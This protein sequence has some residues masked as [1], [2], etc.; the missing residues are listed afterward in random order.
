MLLIV[1]TE[2]QH[3]MYMFRIGVKSLIIDETTGSM[4][5]T[6]SCWLSLSSRGIK[7][8]LISVE[9]SREYLEFFLQEGKRGKSPGRRMQLMWT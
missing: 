4:S 6:Y 3:L 8:L 5:C 1:A 2:V 7:A 9:L